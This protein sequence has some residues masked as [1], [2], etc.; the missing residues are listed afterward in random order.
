[1]LR[2]I[3]T[4][5]LFA[6]SSLNV[7][8]AESEGF[9]NLDFDVT[10]ADGVDTTRDTRWRHS[11]SYEHGWAEEGGSIVQRLAWRPQWDGLIGDRVFFSLDARL[12]VYGSQDRFT[13]AGRD[14]T[15]RM[16][17]R[18]LFL[19]SSGE[20]WAVLGGYQVI[21]LG[22]MDIV[23]ISDVFAPWDFSE[24]AW[25][26]PEDAR[27]GQP[28]L[29]VSHFSGAGSLHAWVN[30]RAEVTRYPVDGLGEQVAALLGT[31]NFVLDDDAPDY[32]AR[33]EVVLRYQHA[34]GDIEQ[35]Y[36]LASLVQNDPA[37]ETTALF[38]VPRLRAVYPRYTMAAWGLSRVR[39]NVLWKVEAAWKQ[40]IRPSDTNG[41]EVDSLDLGVGMEYNA[42]ED[43]RLTLE[44]SRY[45]R[46]YPS[47]VAA[48]TDDPW[49]LAARWSRDFLNQT[50][51][52][53]A[54]AARSQPGRVTTT[55]LS[56][57]Y[58]LQ[59]D[60]IVE[61]AATHVDVGEA[62]L[63]APLLE[64]ASATVLRARYHW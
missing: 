19:Q 55:S 48:T 58:R 23:A 57:T 13:P 12:R 32:F 35:E 11:L 26:A 22:F 40:G 56:L 5:L 44:A 61:L 9:D 34:H 38:P 14:H 21:N 7:L 54:F 50:L 24:P 16:R 52:V 45:F 49:Q 2:R 47:A 64:T 18:S 37:F 53:V 10:T 1:M 8:A 41:V 62:T 20:Q 30:A 15:G 46:Q 43:W 29:A 42:A 3:A 33:G 60:W 39:D 6:A 4:V 36:I 63:L 51:S 27:L 28:V 17:I 31:T 59:D 25:T